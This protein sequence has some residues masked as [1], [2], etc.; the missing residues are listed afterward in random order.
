[1]SRLAIIAGAGDLPAELQAHLP[2]KPFVCAVEGYPPAG[3]APDLSFRIE[4]LVP[5]FRQLTDAGVSQV[6]FAGVIHRPRLDP[7]LFDPETAAL[8]PRLLPAL[9]RGDDALLR[10]VIDVFEEHGLAVRGLADCAPGLLAEAGILGAAPLDTRQDA[11]AA[12]GTEILRG[13]DPL[14]LGQGCVVA[15]GLCLAVES[16]YGTDAML[17]HVAACRD[18]REP[19]R[20]GVFVKR[21][22][23]GQDL[24]IDLP[25]IGPATVEA[26]RAAR[27]SGICLQAR[28]V[29]VLHRE[30]VRAAAD[31]AG[32]A[33]WAVP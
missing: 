7:A 20:G 28:H 25:A 4:R 29:V 18:L 33:L 5:L 8:M 11:D 1:M 30:Q 15:G 24:R 9:Q 26:A 12:R 16:L 10:A 3:L 31:A 2:E 21:A 32:I 6:L 19:R 23:A 27:L 22:K 13:L 17:S 14:D